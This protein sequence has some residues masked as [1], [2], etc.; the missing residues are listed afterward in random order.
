MNFYDVLAAEKLGGGIPTTNFF[1]LLFAQF[2]SGKKWEVYEGTLPATLNANGDDMRQYRIYGNTGGVGDDSG[3]AYGYEV[4]IGVKSGNVMPSAPAETKTSNGIMVTCDGK[5][6]YSISGTASNNSDAYINFYFSE[7]TP[8]VAIDSGG[9]GVFFCFNDF[10]KSFSDL[11]FQFF[12]ND[13]KIYETS[14]AQK[15][16]VLTSY[17]IS[18]INRFRLY[19]RRGVTVS[20]DFSLMFTDSGTVSASYQPYSNITTP[21][22]IGSDP[23]GKDEYIDY[24]AQKVYRMINSALTPTD[25]PVPLP[26]LPTCEGTTIVDYAGQSVAPEKVVF[27]YAKGGS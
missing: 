24:Q 26:A 9:N 8:P 15:N 25:P 13:N 22:Y 27:E 2:I 7:F 21:I 20:G 16:K 19:V 1:D 11:V 6:R 3:T 5:G 12:K 17:S 4:D 18:A 10:T 23:L 14:F